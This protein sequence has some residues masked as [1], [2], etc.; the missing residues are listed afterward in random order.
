MTSSEKIWYCSMKT[1]GA[2]FIFVAVCQ[3]KYITHLT[4]CTTIRQPGRANPIVY[5]KACPKVI[6]R[7]VFHHF[8]C[9]VCSLLGRVEGGAVEVRESFPG[10]ECLSPEQQSIIKGVVQS[11][12]A[13][14]DPAAAVRQA[15]ALRGRRLQAGDRSFD[16]S[17]YRRVRVI[18]AGKAA[19]AMAR[20]L[21]GVLGDRISDG[22]LVTKH[23]EDS[24][25]LPPGIDVLLGGH[26]VP[27]QDSVNST[28]RLVEYLRESAAGDLVIC[29][30]SGGGSALLTWPQAGV[31][32]DDLQALTRLLLAC[33]A[34]ITEMNVLRKHLDQV[35]GGGL[36]RLAAPGEVITLILSD[37]IGS[38]LDVIASGPT[39]PDTSTFG[40]AYAILEKYRL[41]EKVPEAVGA[42]LRKGMAGDLPET[43]KAGDPIFEK[44]TNLVVASNAQAALAGLDRARQAGF[45]TL[46]L[47]TYLQG[48]AAQ[49]GGLLASLLKEIDASGNPLPRPA[50]LAA[51]GE[52]TVTVRGEGLGGRNQELALGAALLLDGVPGVALLTLGTD[53]EDGPTGAAG[54]LACGDTLARAR[55]LGLDPQDHLARNDSYHF[56]QATGDLLVTGPT[57]TNVNDLA[58]LFAF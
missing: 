11:A 26:P 39:V 6:K 23:R 18:G 30:I 36:A 15:L 54:A 52:T 25:G 53:G 40:Q 27:T 19:Q 42:V 45:H 9:A 14:V 1:A 29:L 4:A 50:C 3:A 17:A 43:L 16:L 20:G 57:G 28:G 21:T 12:L 41:V 5:K 51:G 49:A 13:A 47:T 44:V 24:G 55:R 7:P 48:E 34:D 58:F 10:A 32:L 38:P 22:V 2:V 8:F 56:F 33:G 35:K 31:T 37:V 46:L